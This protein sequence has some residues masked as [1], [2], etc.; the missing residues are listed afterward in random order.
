[1]FKQA[2]TVI[3]FDVESVGLHGEGFAYG[4]VVVSLESR[5]ICEEHE[6]YCNPRPEWGTNEGFD[7]IQKNCMAPLHTRAKTYV[8][9]PK[10]VRDFF[11]TLWERVKRESEGKALLAA[12]TA[13]P[14]EARFLARCVDDMRPSPTFS[15]SDK[16]NPRYW[17]GP[18]P[19]I[20]I[21]T[22]LAVCPDANV[23][24]DE[25]LGELPEHDPLA[26]ARHS[27][28]QMIHALNLLESPKAYHSGQRR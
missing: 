14:V 26:D 8:D 1:M 15:N 9:S 18:Y 19:L 25:A 12:D 13:W 11:W 20:D 6:V 27:A 21:A 7:F 4:A 3:V 17:E 16:D 28:R 22:L 5:H 23:P 24:R 10:T 2:T